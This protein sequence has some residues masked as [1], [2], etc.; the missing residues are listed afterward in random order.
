[1]WSID[2]FQKRP[3]GLAALPRLVRVYIL[4]TL[5]G[6]AISAVFTALVIAYDVVGIGHLV[7]NVEGGWL[8]AAVF[9]ILNGIVFSGVQFGIVVMSMDETSPPD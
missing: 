2:P 6:F 4:H 8:A 3:K 7:S 9:F 1:M 5:I